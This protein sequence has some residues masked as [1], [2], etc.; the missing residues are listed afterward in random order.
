MGDMSRRSRF[1][2][3]FVSTPLVAFVIV[4]GLLG[5]ARRVP[6]QALKPLAPFTD[7]VGLIINDYVDNV[8]IDKV[9]DGA[10]R[11]LVDDLDSSSAYLMPDDVKAIDANTPLGPADVGLVVTHQFYMRVVGIRDGSP[12]ARAKLESGDFIRMI[13]GTATR[14]MSIVTGTRLLHGAA[15]AKVSLLVIR[16]NAA[17]PHE[18]D[19]T[20]EMPAADHVT[21]KRLPGGQAYLRPSSF[22]GARAGINSS[23]SALGAAANTGLIIDLRDVADGT[24]DDGIAAAR[25]FV[26]SGTI[27]T[28]AGR[29]STDRVV[30]TATDGDGALSMPLIL[31]VSNGT[32]N[33]AEL[34]AAA[35]QGNKRA[36]IV[37]EPTAGLAS[38]QHLVP[39]PEGYGLWL[40]YRRYLRADGTP[41]LEHGLKPDA[42]VDIPGIS[43][44]ETPPATDAPLARAAEEL[45][46]LEQGGAVDAPDATAATT[47]PAP[48]PE[49]TKPSAPNNPN[50][51]TSPVPPVPPAPGRGAS[52]PAQ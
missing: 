46:R 29:E 38:E 39:L 32:G 41:I 23:V 17:D 7:A 35:L 51:S 30:T 12:A 10:M 44:D 16:G 15:G 28:L 21:G 40:T 22:V 4:G 6:Q 37:G 47:T 14:D 5:A 19:L 42:F 49:T 27:A 43:F 24:A 26:K 2:I 18:I 13:N 34:F 50:N 1:V 36:R 25:L 33:A 11:G 45:K 8:N 9:F 3:L 20:Y 52:P 31:L 48:A